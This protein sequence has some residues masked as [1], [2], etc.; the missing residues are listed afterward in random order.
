MNWAVIILILIVVWVTQAGLTIMQ[1]RNYRQCVRKLINRKEGE[2]IGVGSGR[3]W[4]RAGTVVIMVA[5]EEG[6]V[7]NAERMH[8]IS[9]FARFKPWSAINGLNVMDLAE[10]NFNGRELSKT[11]YKAVSKAAKII[12]VKMKEIEEGSATS[13]NGKEEEFEDD[14]DPNV[15]DEGYSS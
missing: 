11:G 6:K 9:V 2:Y 4:F 1:V 12:L 5:D 3:G 13:L 15:A 7:V 8:G 10:E 14:L